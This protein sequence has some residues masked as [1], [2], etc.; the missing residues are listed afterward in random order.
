MF[1]NS[2]SSAAVQWRPWR[3]WLHLS[4]FLQEAATI[5]LSRWTI[6]KNQ[7]ISMTGRPSWGKSSSPS[8]TWR[9]TI[10]SGIFPC[11]FYSLNEYRFFLENKMTV[12]FNKSVF[13]V[14]FLLNSFFYGNILYTFNLKFHFAAGWLLNPL[15]WYL[16]GSIAMTRKKAFSSCGLAWWR[17]MWSNFQKLWQ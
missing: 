16:W 17:M 4:P 14:Y 3:R 5:S 8:H 7:S 10:I 12:F 6:P 2:W 11:S 9:N 13:Y 15:V 1:F